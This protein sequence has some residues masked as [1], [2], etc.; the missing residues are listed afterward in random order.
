M[1]ILSVSSRLIFHYLPNTLASLLYCVAIS[2]L[3]KSETTITHLKNFVRIYSNTYFVGDEHIECTGYLII[4]TTVAGLDDVME[5]Q[6]VQFIF[7]N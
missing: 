3:G 4:S 1:F 5:L 7:N 6:V 2:V